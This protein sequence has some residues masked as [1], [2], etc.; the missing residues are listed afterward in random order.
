MLVTEAR[1][2]EEVWGRRMAEGF[3]L[4]FPLALNLDMYLAA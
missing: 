3:E 2:P 4:W 1:W